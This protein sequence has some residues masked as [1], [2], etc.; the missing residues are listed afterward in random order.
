MQVVNQKEVSYFEKIRVKGWSLFQII[1]G[2]FFLAVL[3][4]ISI[5]LYPVPLSLQTFGVFLLAICQGGKGAAKSLIVY[6]MF[7]SLGLPVLA[8]G[9]SRPLWILSPCAG[10][11]AAFPIAAYLI[12]KRVE[13]KGTA[14]SLQIIGS[15][16]IGNGVVFVL[17]VGYLTRFLS[18]AQSVSVGLLPFLP[19]EG[20]KILGAASIGGLYFRWKNGGRNSLND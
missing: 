10:Y 8:F 12:G 16:C 11:L 14:S 6:L 15:L 9:V 19:I 2:A 17:G 3:S 13:T 20:I 5:P 4:Q 7:A 18:F 1:G